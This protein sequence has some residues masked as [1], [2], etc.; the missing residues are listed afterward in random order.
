MIVCFMIVLVI[1]ST[2][3]DALY[4]TLDALYETTRPMLHPI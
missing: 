1:A 2:T 3:V 4:E